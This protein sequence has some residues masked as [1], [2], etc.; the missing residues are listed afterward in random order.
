[1]TSDIATRTLWCYIE[2]DS[3]TFE[4]TVP[5]TASIHRLKEVVHEKR[6][7]GVLSKVDA[8]DLVLWK[9]CAVG[10]MSTAWLTFLTGRYRYQR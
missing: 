1:M 4:V 2:G 10:V 8:S 9:V 6:K 3:T 7:N 5:V